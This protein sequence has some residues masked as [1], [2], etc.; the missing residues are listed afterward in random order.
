MVSI[1]N[2]NPTKGNLHI[3]GVIQNDNQQCMGGCCLD[4][5]ADHFL[6]RYVFLAEFGHCFQIGSDLLR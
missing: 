3:R 5:D 2:C 1:S 6:V 4:E